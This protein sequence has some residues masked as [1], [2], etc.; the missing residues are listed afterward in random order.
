[1]SA[2]PLEHQ[3]TNFQLEP[4][5]SAEHW[6]SCSRLPNEVRTWQE[7]GSDRWG[8]HAPGEPTWASKLRWTSEELQELVKRGSSRGGSGGSPE[9]EAGAGRCCQ[10]AGLRAQLHG[11]GCLVPALFSSL[12]QGHSGRRRQSVRMPQTL[13]R[14]PEDSHRLTPSRVSLNQLLISLASLSLGQLHAFGSS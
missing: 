5:S 4:K 12:R 3:T 7:F 14:R 9:N 10:S 13:P 2:P 1:M 8:S 11:G 6:V